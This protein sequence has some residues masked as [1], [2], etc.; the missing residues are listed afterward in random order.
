M[1]DSVEGP[2]V[3]NLTDGAETGST[4]ANYAGLGDVSPSP[5]Y[6]FQSISGFFA[7]LHCLVLQFIAMTFKL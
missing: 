5:H 1:A 4:R 2:P 7:R 6:T 3:P